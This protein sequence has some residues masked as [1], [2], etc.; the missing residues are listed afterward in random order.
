MHKPLATYELYRQKCGMV[1]EFGSGRRM[2]GHAPDFNAIAT[3]V[4]K[5]RASEVVSSAIVP[6]PAGLITLLLAA[7]FTNHVNFRRRSRT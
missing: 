4:G 7:K 5:T 3:N 1:G 2:S 6:E